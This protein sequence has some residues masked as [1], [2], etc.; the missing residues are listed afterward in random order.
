MFLLT[1]RAIVDWRRDRPR[2]DDNAT[3]LGC[4]KGQIRELSWRNN[5]FALLDSTGNCVVDVA[6]ED[7]LDVIDTDAF[8][9]DDE[10]S[11][12]TPSGPYVFYQSRRERAKLMSLIETL[13]RSSTTFRAA[14][15]RRRR[16]FLR[17]GLTCLPISLVVVVLMAPPIAFQFLASSEKP[18]SLLRFAGEGLLGIL[19]GILWL[20]VG[21]L[22]IQS[23][24]RLIIARKLGALLACGR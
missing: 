1:W 2:E 21:A 22:T 18:D 24:Q 5:R 13:A 9:L 3:A 19:Y 6:L 20:G 4:Y 14:I 16:E 11:I 23:M 10:V 17:R 12:H 15:T 8:F 7:A